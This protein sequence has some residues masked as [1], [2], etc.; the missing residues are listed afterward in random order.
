M[1]NVGGL[2]TGSVCA[3]GI[4]LVIAMMSGTSNART[5]TV[6]TSGASTSGMCNITDAIKAASTNTAVRGCAAG[7]LWATDTIVLAA[8]TAYQAYGAPL[9]VPAGG[10]Q[11]VIRGTLSSG[12]VTTTIL[13]RNYGYPSPNPINSTVC[14]YPAAIFTGGGTVTIRDLNL[15]ADSF[16]EGKTGICQYSGGLTLNNVGIYQFDRGGLWSYPNTST[17]TRTLTIVTTDIMFNHSPV[18]G[19]AVSLFGSM[20]ASLTN[21]VI[22]E[23]NSD[24]SGGAL[25]WN[26]HGTLTITDVDFNFNRSIYSM[27]GAANINP[28][29][30]NAIVTFNNVSFLGNAASHYGGAIWVGDNV[31]ING[32][33]L[34][35]T[36]FSEN[37]GTQHPDVPDDPAHNSFNADPGVYDRIYC[38]ASSTITWL[39]VYP[40]TLHNPRLKGDG[41]CTFP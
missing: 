24:E 16:L 23:N 14:Q 29:T 19:A 35:N 5:I 38:T 30:S 9:H 17:N 1:E 20:T 25:H 3:V 4:A 28:D 10:G 13:G 12:D 39:N 31:A 34:Q 32:L 8:N 6:N 18:V 11:L 41:T 15:Q 7:E 33:K 2:R 26:G 22:Q 21:M 36:H 27:G 40:W 37:L